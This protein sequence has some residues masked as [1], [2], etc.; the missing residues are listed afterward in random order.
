M[1]ADL[2]SV[3]MIVNKDL[4]CVRAFGGRPQKFYMSSAGSQVSTI[5]NIGLYAHLDR[6]GLCFHSRWTEPL[7]QAPGAAAASRHGSHGTKR[8]E[9]PPTRRL[10][11]RILNGSRMPRERQ[12][13]R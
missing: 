5:E 6:Q 8:V 10:R 3:L 4:A 12:A 7:N 2:G 11:R 9:M 13:R 1:L